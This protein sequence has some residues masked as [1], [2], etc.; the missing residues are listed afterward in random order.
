MRSIN[1]L[2]LILLIAAATAMMTGPESAIV[3]GSDATVEE[4]PYMA[5]VFNLGLPTCGGAIINTRSVLTAAHCILIRNAA[6]VS[7]SVGS[8]RRRG[9]GGT[10]YRAVRVAIHPE[11]V[12]IRFD[13]I[14]ADV[15][16][17]RTLTRIRFGALVQP[18]PLGPNAVTTAAQVV[19]T[20]WGQ[21]GDVSCYLL[22]QRSHITSPGGIPIGERGWEEGRTGGEGRGVKGR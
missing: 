9:Q 18:I 14:R 10:T 4:Y 15:A 16:V 13:A 19:L 3:G 20:A 7:V 22:G 1:S 5:G 11:F 21:V 2:V 17:I 12:Y 8:S 6:T